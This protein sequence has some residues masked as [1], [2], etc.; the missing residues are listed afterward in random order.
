MITFRQ[1]RQL[2]IT[3]A[4]PMGMPARMDDIYG[5]DGTTVVQLGP[6]S[7]QLTAFL[8]DI[9]QHSE[10]YK[11]NHRD[12]Y[13]FCSTYFQCGATV[14]AAPRAQQIRRVY[15][16]PHGS[17]C[18]PVFLDYIQDFAD[19]FNRMRLVS[20][21]WDAPAN[22][23]LPVLPNGFFFNRQ[24]EATDTTDKGLRWAWGVWTLH[25]GR[26]YLGPRIEHWEQ[27]VVDWDGI[28][29]AWAME[30]R[31]PVN[32]PY[33]DEIPDQSME[34]VNVAVPWVKKYE[35]TY[36]RPDA[37]LSEEMRRLWFESR[38][39]LLLMRDAEMKAQLQPVR[40][41]PQVAAPK[42][43]AKLPRH[44]QPS[45]GNDPTFTYAFVGDVTAGSSAAAVAELIRS[46]TPDYVIANGGMWDATDENTAADL[47]ANFGQY[48]ARWMF[49]YAGTEGTSEASTQQLFAAYGNQERD[50]SSRFNIVRQFFNL[51]PT[52]PSNPQPCRGYYEKRLG[53]AHFFFIDS[54]YEND[55]TTVAQPDGNTYTSA[56]GTYFR[57]RIQGSNAR[58]KFV[59]MSAPPYSSSTGLPV[60]GGF[61]AL[62][63]PFQQ[64]GTDAAF[65][66]HA[67]QYERLAVDGY[68]YFVAG[69]GGQT[70]NGF[71]DP[72]SAYS[73]KNLESF[74]AIRL[75]LTCD[76]AV[77]RFFQTDG[78]IFD[79]L[80]ITK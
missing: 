58:W 30:D 8:I 73:V 40:S 29:Y 9:Q 68:P 75:D 20:P 70:L 53:P 63:W 1:F 4:W 34:L 7:L 12:I 79:T 80:E 17:D 51:L 28:R 39:V 60:A 25:Q 48:Y 61:A 77:I 3:S 76:R 69:T 36:V 6:L 56:Q 33:S 52:D 50:P 54:G 43:D 23:D 55:L 24:S 45:D 2:V 11:Q 26:L 72:L 18:C 10:F 65:S 78:T 19:W 37:N 16:Q 22:S 46:W 59:V 62:R 14:L 42:I 71:T 5:D 31:V 15:T 64:W 41:F 38:R 27:V 49:P 35:F 74:G 66:A 13:P 47:D 32:G 44:C 67:G 21:R 57:Q